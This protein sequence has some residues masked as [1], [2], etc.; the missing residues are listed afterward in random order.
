M[1][2][3]YNFLDRKI[4]EKLKL[5]YNYNIIYKY[6]IRYRINNYI[7]S[8]QKNQIKI[9]IINQNSSIWFEI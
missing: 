1:I 9:K 5:N 7:I 3:I 4:F 8:I 6:N 2:Y